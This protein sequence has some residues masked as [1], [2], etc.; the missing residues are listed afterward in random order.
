M[1]PSPKA[2]SPAA[3]AKPTAPFNRAGVCS[4]AAVK[5]RPVSPDSFSGFWVS[6][7]DAA[8]SDGKA[9]GIASFAGCADAA[10]ALG[11]AGAP[12][13]GKEKEIGPLGCS[14][15][16]GAAAGAGDVLS[17]RRGAGCSGSGSRATGLESRGSTLESIPRTSRR[18][19]VSLSKYRPSVSSTS[20]ESNARGRPKRSR[21]SIS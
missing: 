2:F 12:M 1:P 4:R 16:A 6:G 11:A 3:P 20:V 19:A 5:P 9:K 10:G 14:A 17:A 18:R 13:P 15:G 7:A 21:S 8:W